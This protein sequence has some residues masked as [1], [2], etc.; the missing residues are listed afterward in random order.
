MPN[1]HDH[2]H[3]QP[4]KIPQFEQVKESVGF[5]QISLGLFQASEQFFVR[6]AILFCHFGI[7]EV[8]VKIR[9][10]RMAVQSAGES[11]ISEMD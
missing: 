3:R 10:L 6:F 1:S 11:L 4:A 9:Q 7:I 8:V 2:R 5:Q